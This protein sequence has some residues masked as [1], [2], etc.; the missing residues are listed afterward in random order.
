[1]SEITKD[2]LDR[3]ACVYVRQSK[4]IQVERNVESKQRQYGLADRAR[5]L[6][7][8]EIRVID[9]DL[10]RSA[11]GN[12]SRSGFDTLMAEVCQGHVG[13]VFATEASRLAR[14]GQDWH[15]LL[16]FCAIVG[17]L[18]VDHDGVYDPRHP[19]DRLVLGL[20]G[21]L[22]EMEIST[23]RQRSQEAIRQ[24]ARRGE[25]YAYIPVGYILTEDGQLEKSPDEHVRSTIEL[26]FAKFRELGSARQVQIWFRQEDIPLPRRIGRKHGPIE[27]VRPTPWVIT[28]ILKEPLYAG[29]YAHGRTKRRVVLE[30]G[31]K[32]V[33]RQDRLRPEDWDVL[34]ID[35]H[36]GYISWQEYVQNLQTL[37]HN[38]TQLGEAARGP[39]RC[40]KGLLAGLIR[41]GRCGRKMQVQ[42]GGRG[43]TRPTASY[44]CTVPRAEQIDSSLCSHFGGTT[45]EQAVSEAVL[46]ALAPVRMQAMLDASDRV[47]AKRLA[48]RKQMELELERARYEADRHQRQYQAV[49]PENRL[50]ARTLEVRW[51]QALE[52]VSQLERELEK[53]PGAEKVLS[54]QDQERLRY[55]AAELPRVWNHP[56]A[57]FELKKRVLRSVIYE[58]VIYAE[59]QSLRVLVHWQGGQHTEMNLRRRKPGEHRWTTPEDT[60]ELIRQLARRMPDIQIAGQLNRMGIKSAKGHT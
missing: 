57:P 28:K 45:V 3:V 54:L 34:I 55:L 42:Y 27:F 4:M 9:D 59:K 31:V 5:E 40:G 49:E 1:M 41:C 11:N 24:K 23:F 48:R 33:W 32:R 60:C 20:K 18:I 19:N 56:A 51:N 17:S 15:R 58:I 26:V 36:E 29:A 14:N 35:H 2:H 52:T 7:W 10:G 47:A 39:A 25:H 46:H 38:R 21:T 22:S 16:E 37:A 6:G 50:V 44:V 43:R 13:A 12:T 53:I 30:N 8:R